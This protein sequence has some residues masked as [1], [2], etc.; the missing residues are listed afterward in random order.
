MAERRPDTGDQAC[1]VPLIE[2][3]RSIPKDYRTSRAIQWADDGRETGHQFIPVGYM[4]HRAADE[5]E[6]AQRSETAPTIPNAWIIYEPGEIP[7]RVTAR[8]GWKV[9]I[10]SEK[11]EARCVGVTIDRAEVI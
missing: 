5:L 4:M 9:E 2:Q 7:K 3:L 10:D 1:E 6:K 8:D 11:P